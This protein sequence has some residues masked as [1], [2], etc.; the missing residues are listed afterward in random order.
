VEDGEEAVAFNVLHSNF[1]IYIYHSTTSI[2]MWRSENGF[3]VECEKG[4]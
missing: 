4:V 1:N 2:S 3:H